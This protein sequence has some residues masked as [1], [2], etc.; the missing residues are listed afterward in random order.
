MPVLSDIPL[1][2]VLDIFDNAEKVEFVKKELPEVL[3]FINNYLRDYNVCYTRGA[4]IEQV[5]SF[6]NRNRKYLSDIA[7]ACVIEQI[8][9][10]YVPVVKWNEIDK[11][12]YYPPRE[13]EH[14][15]LYWYKD[16]VSPKASCIVHMEFID[17]DAPTL[18]QCERPKV[19]GVC[20][21]PSTLG[22]SNNL[23]AF[24][25]RVVRALKGGQ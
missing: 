7:I 4:T 24:H 25:Q 15:K 6:R 20:V 5:I 1:L 9:T 22:T 2:T 19:K 21:D 12:T 10:N 16:D 13:N 11:L 8:F 18:I 3:E 23:L 17:P 14:I